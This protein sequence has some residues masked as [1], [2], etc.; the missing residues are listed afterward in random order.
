MCLSQISVPSF[1]EYFV[2]W[3]L[4]LFY[5]DFV[6]VIIKGGEILGHLSDCQLFKDCPQ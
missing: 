5:A 2:C 1:V 4:S 3:L 6:S